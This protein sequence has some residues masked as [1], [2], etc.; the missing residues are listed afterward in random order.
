MLKIIK[1]KQAELTQR[2][3]LPPKCAEYLACRLIAKQDI[4]HIKIRLQ[5][6][7]REAEITLS[8]MVSVVPR[9][10]RWLANHPQHKHTEFH[11]KRLAS[12]K[13]EMKRYPEV[14]NKYRYILHFLNSEQGKDMA[15]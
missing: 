1:K 7:I 2:Y 3:N 6:K 10:E 15:E 13:E 14:I 9:R 5:D 4:E 8:K 11:T 12:L